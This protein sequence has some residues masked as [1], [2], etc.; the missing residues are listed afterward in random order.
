M[1]VLPHEFRTWG[2]DAPVHAGTRYGCRVAAPDHVR[3]I[4]R[5]TPRVLIHNMVPVPTLW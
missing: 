5:A 2:L 4:Y 1:F 3:R